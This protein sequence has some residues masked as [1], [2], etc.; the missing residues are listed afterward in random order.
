MLAT[1]VFNFYAWYVA[2]SSSLFM[3]QIKK[4]QKLEDYSQSPKAKVS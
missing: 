3:S 4:K 1:K 2:S